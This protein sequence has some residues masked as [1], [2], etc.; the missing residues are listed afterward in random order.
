MLLLSDLFIDLEQ[1]EFV[2]RHMKML[3][4]ARSHIE[5]VDLGNVI[6]VVLK[7][8][9]VLGLVKHLLFQIFNWYCILRHILSLLYGLDIVTEC[10]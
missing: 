6:C 4:A 10:W 8:V 5:S 3:F 1:F 2:F 9:A 7:C